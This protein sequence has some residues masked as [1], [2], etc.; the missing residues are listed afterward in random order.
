M[1]RIDFFDFFD[2]RKNDEKVD[3]TQMGFEQIL[4]S[5]ICFWEIFTM[6]NLSSFKLGFEKFV[7][8]KYWPSRFFPLFLC[9]KKVEKVGKRHIF[10]EQFLFSEIFFWEIFPIW[11]LSSFKLGFK[12]IVKIWS[13][14]SRHFIRYEWT[15]C[16]WNFA[17]F[18][19]KIKIYIFRVIQSRWP[20]TC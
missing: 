18:C 1:R 6:W 12:N 2:V 14:T 17:G 5:E 20:P 7:E 3:P 15:H 8:K 4:F 11:N 9:Q 19:G 16:K 10:F 13:T